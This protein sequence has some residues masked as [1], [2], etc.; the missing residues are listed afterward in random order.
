MGQGLAGLGR[1][2]HRVERMGVVIARAGHDD[3][4]NTVSAVP[5]GEG[6]VRPAEPTAERSGR[7]ARPM[8]DVHRGQEPFLWELMLSREDL[9]VALDRVE[10]N[11]GAPGVDGMATAELRP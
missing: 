4:R 3:R 8:T 7:S 10:A 9:L 1:A 11:R 5:Q 6:S 2:E